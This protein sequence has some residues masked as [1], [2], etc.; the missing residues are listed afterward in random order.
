[1]RATTALRVT[2][3][4]ASGTR[5]RCVLRNVESRWA[6]QAYVESLWGEAVYLAMIWLRGGSGHG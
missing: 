2:H 3:I 4:D 5:H 1:M 6:A